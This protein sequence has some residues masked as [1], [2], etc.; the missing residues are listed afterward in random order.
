VW[1]YQ[2]E[3]ETQVE[4][5]RDPFFGTLMPPPSEAFQTAA[6]LILFTDATYIVIC[7]GDAEELARTA[8]EAGSTWKTTPFIVDS[9]DL[10]ITMEL[11]TNQSMRLDQGNAIPAI[12][13]YDGTNHI[14]DSGRGY[15]LPRSD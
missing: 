1:D 7:P 3:T 14:V 8:R 4:A 5:F 9:R 12:L 10:S 15:V 2:L 11:V 6:Q 13:Q